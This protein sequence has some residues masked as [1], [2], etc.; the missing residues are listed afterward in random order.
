MDEKRLTKIRLDITTPSSGIDW[1]DLHR[2]NLHL[3]WPKWLHISITFQ[4]WCL[5]RVGASTRERIYWNEGRV[6][7]QNTW[8]LQEKSVTLTPQ[9]NQIWLCC[10]LPLLTIGN[11]NDNYY[12]YLLINKM[13]R[14]KYPQKRYNCCMTA[15]G[16]QK[17]YIKKYHKVVSAI[18]FCSTEGISSAK[19][20]LTFFV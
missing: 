16:M 11:C 3:K 9:C 1:N 7:W 5:V 19:Y 18:R 6:M 17:V 4:L 13:Y 2:F 8:S 15:R 14:T 20:A 12:Y 10:Q